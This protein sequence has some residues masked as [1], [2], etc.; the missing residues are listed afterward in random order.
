[1]Y[2]YGGR[3][4]R[5][6]DADTLVVD[7]DLGFYLRQEMK[8]RLAGINAPAIRGAEAMRGRAAAAFVAEQIERNPVL[9][10]RTYKIEKWGRYLADVFIGPEGMDPRE[11]FTGGT[12]LNRLL[13]DQGLASIYGA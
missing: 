6:I 5:V 7:V 1:M 10:I 12:H 9:G 13:L 11:V 8:L 2:E 3:L 4:L